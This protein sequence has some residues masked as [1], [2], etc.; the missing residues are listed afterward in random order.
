MRS[1]APCSAVLCSEVETNVLE[2]SA[3]WVGTIHYVN[4]QGS[5]NQVTVLR[6]KQQGR[7]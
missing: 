3:V 5:Q 2:F 7:N 6:T 1:V 4:M